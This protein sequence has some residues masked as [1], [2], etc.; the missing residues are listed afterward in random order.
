MLSR[1]IYRSWHFQYKIFT[2]PVIILVIIIIVIIIII[3]ITIVTI[4]FEYSE[5][6]KW[7][8]MV[9]KLNIPSYRDSKSVKLKQTE[10]K[11]NE[12]VFILNVTH[13]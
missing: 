3:F 8:R 10:T 5:Y 11:M 1:C 7:N 12:G 9:S 13:S 2:L 4:N 6:I